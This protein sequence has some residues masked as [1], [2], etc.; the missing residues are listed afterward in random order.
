[1]KRG[2]SGSA[3]AL[4]GMADLLRTWAA[5]AAALQSL[6]RRQFARALSGRGLAR[7]MKNAGADPQSVELHHGI[8]AGG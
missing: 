4:E 5:V 7:T 8:P 3:T 1:M 2:W 6:A